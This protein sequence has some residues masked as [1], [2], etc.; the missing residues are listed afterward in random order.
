MR[1]KFTEDE[2]NTR[3]WLIASNEGNKDSSEVVLSLYAQLYI[4]DLNVFLSLRGLRDL[5]P[6]MQWQT[7]KPLS[8]LA[9]HT[10]LSSISVTV[11]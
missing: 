5:G 1:F 6:L 4:Y 2:F 7:L 11:S 9:Q 10:F 8:N 3:F